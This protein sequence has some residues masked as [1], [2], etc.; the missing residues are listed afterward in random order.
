MKNWHIYDNIP[1]GLLFW[2]IFQR[3]GH[4]S[5]RFWGFWMFFGVFERSI[6]GLPIPGYNRL[7]YFQ[8]RLTLTAVRLALQLGPV[9]SWLFCS[10]FEVRHIDVMNKQ[11]WA[12][13]AWSRLEYVRGPLRGI[14][15]QSFYLDL[16]L[17]HAPISLLIPV[18]LCMILSLF[19]CVLRCSI[20][21]FVIL[22]AAIVTG[23]LWRPSRYKG[24]GWWL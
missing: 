12:L 24:S 10:Q 6:I 3:F 13:V 19:H 17:S 2:L 14:V 15:L 5:V 7:F 22:I 20:A 1:Q 8:N 16:I 23:R 21:S 18:Y 11:V 4:N 9:R